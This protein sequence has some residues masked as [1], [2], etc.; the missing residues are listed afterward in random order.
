MSPWTACLLLSLTAPGAD[1]AASRPVVDVWP[2]EP[3]GETA[4]LAKETDRTKPTD[5]LVAG[6]RIIRLGNVSKPTLTVFLPAKEKANG[7]AVVVCP[8][9]GYTILAWDLEGTEVCA[10]LNS[11]GVTAVLLKY[12]VP[13]RPKVPRHQAALQDG[14]RAMSLTRSKAKEWG[15]D[16]KRIGILG[17]SAGGNLSAR[18][19]TAYARRAYDAV[20]GVDEVSGRPDFVVLVY[21][22]WLANKQGDALAEDFKVTRDTPPMFLA[23]AGDDPVAAESSVQM[24]LSLRRAKV[25]AELHVWEKGGHGYGLRKTD[26]PVTT[27]PKRCAEWLKGRGLLERR[28]KE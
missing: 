9:G 27:W 24:Y 26:Q 12:R 28:P 8:G 11:L 4:K 15:I 21:P 13:A 5:G 22:A 1:P 6:K 10:W 7:T 20:D 19:A 25:P 17:F 23:H 3:P 14:Q 16:P 18:V 2:A